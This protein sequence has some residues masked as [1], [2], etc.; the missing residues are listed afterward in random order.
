MK[1]SGKSLVALTLPIAIVVALLTI[2]RHEHAVTADQLKLGISASRVK[3]KKG[4]T[5][6][7]QGHG[8]SKT[9][10]TAKT[11][12]HDGGYYYVECEGGKVV[13]V[14]VTY[15]KPV[16]RDVCLSTL[17]RLTANARVIE[18]DTTELTANS[19]T[20]AAKPFLEPMEEGDKM[21]ACEYFYFDNGDYAELQYASPKSDGISRLISYARL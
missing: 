4:F 10:Y 13:S 6:L 15:N 16:S 17:R 20:G 14:Y 5:Y 1:L 8:A 9:Q 21:P 12:D 2:V 11:A 3:G 18:T 19:S 7:T